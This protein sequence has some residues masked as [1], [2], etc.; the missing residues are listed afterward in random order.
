[1]VSLRFAS[2]RDTHRQ[3]SRDEH[4]PFRSLKAVKLKVHPI[5]HW[6]ERRVRAHLLVC[7]RTNWNGTC[8][9]A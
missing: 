6:R 5:F 1:M 2:L 9:G 7:L 8:G 3:Q 4:S